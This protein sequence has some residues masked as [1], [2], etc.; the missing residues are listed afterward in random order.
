SRGSRGLSRTS[1]RT[2]IP[3]DKRR[4]CAPVDGF[5]PTRVTCDAHPA[6]VAI[7][8]IVSRVWVSDGSRRLSQCSVACTTVVQRLAAHGE[9]KH[10]A[11]VIFS[12]QRTLSG[13]AASQNGRTGAPWKRSF[14]LLFAPQA[15]A[16]R[17]AV[18][19]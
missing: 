6:K 18:E 8:P 11:F 10:P 5:A 3:P 12:R 13:C 9:R 2:L 14:P 15:R 4:A 1:R 7:I 19:R 17:I 16:T